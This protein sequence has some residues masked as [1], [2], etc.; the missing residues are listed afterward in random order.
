MRT[1]VF[2]VETK[3]AFDEVG[4][5][6]P[7]KLGVSLVGVWVGE[8]KDNGEMLAYR[9]EN[10]VDMFKLFEKADIIVGFNSVGFDYPALKPY[11]SGDLFSFPSLDMLQKVE[12]SV[13]HRVKL[14]DLAKETLGIQKSGNG[15]DA[16]RYFNDGDFESLEKYCLQDVKVT[17]D[18]YYFGLE[19]KRVKFINKWNRLVE[20]EI[21]FEIKG[22][23]TRKI[24]TTMF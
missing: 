20:V 19:N 16:I 23:K 6:H 22:D 11:Y 12:E 14:D 21:D 18:L 7:E 2:D 9:E 15:L 17:K 10:L 13:G 24:Q 3:R 8:D 4:G 1:V 5:Y